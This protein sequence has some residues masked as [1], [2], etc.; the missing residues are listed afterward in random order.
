MNQTIEIYMHLKM[1]IW[2]LVTQLKQ[3]LHIFVR[4]LFFTKIKYSIYTCTLKKSLRMSNRCILL[5][6][7]YWLL[8]WR[9]MSICELLACPS[10]WDAQVIDTKRERGGGKTTPTKKINL[11]GVESCIRVFKNRLYCSTIKIVQSCL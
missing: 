1:S 3:C 11:G 5:I 8:M 7:T 6:A 2:S 4:F 10:A 9:L